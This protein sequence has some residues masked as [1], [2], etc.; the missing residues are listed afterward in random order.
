[1][2]S[3]VSH[4]PLSL[5]YVVVFV[6][7]AILG[8]FA[9]YVVDALGLT[10]RYRSAW[11]KLPTEYISARPARHWY[12]RLPLFGALT[13]APVVFASSKSRAS[14]RS[15]SGGVSV[16]PG[17]E[18][19][20]FWLRLFL[21]EL[22]F[23]LLILW[24]FSV[25]TRYGVT[26][27]TVGGWGIETVFYWLALCASLV[28]LDDYVIPDL[29]I[30]PGAALGLILTTFV[31]LDGS[32]F[33]LTRFP[34]DFTGERYSYSIALW[35]GAVAR[36]LG[37]HCSVSTLLTLLLALAWSF[38]NFSLL[39]RR[40]YPGKL[41]WGRAAKL[42]LR[43][44]VRSPL[45]P[46]VGL[47]WLLGLFALL[48]L[49]ILEPISAPRGANFSPSHFDLLTNSFLGLCVGALLI[50]AVRLIGGAS[51]GREAMGFGDVLLGGV[52]GSFLGWQGAV[53]VFFLA[54]FLGMVFGL[55]RRAVGAQTEIPYGPF[56]CLASL[57]Y[58][59]KLDFFTGIFAVYFD[60]PV[61]IAIVGAIGFV[62]LAVMLLALRVL[63][64]TLRG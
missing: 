59:I 14:A 43:R 42:F 36:R 9:N 17:W 27:H 19:R 44:I 20:W 21:V 51:L 29:I 47:C 58:L 45:T 8:A 13:L 62:L 64:S 10:P 25:W 5:L 40:F 46:V 11:R 39:D 1:M 33:P 52:I 16:I 4:L 31:P 53:V 49:M 28:D 63:K 12:E 3:D 30:I 24:R 50:W 7:G 54:P 26:A 55:T 18:G 32:F 61:F 60:D 6:L 57:V 48:G 37:L 22:L 35:L 2:L 41:G 38:W 34:L 56:L 23:A 15:A